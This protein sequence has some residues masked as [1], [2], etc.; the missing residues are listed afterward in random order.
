MQQHSMHQVPG[1]CYQ[2]RQLLLLS[3][4][5]TALPAISRGG[6]GDRQLGLIGLAGKLPKD[7]HSVA[8]CRGQCTHR[9]RAC[10]ITTKAAFRWINFMM[11]GEG[12]LSSPKTSALHSSPGILTLESL[13]TACDSTR[14][15]RL[16]SSAPRPCQLVVAP[17]RWPAPRHCRCA[18]SASFASSSASSSY[19]S[20]S[21][22]C[23]AACPPRPALPPP[24][25]A[26]AG[27]ARMRVALAA[28][29]P[30]GVKHSWSPV[31]APRLPNRPRKLHRRHLMSAKAVRVARWILQF[32][33]A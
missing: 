28:S 27:A 18:S 23:S 22:G 33:G 4:Q 14:E 25:S 32:D 9:D 12:M 21:N 8:V 5:S 15:E 3:R 1:S 7:G 2:V 6:E 24:V 31:A 17:C 30:S 26:A 29:L 20:S 13:T 19:S 10:C 16:V 11:D